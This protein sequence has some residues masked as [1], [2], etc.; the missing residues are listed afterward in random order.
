MKN[1]NTTTSIPVHKIFL[2]KK[3]QHSIPGTDYTSINIEDTFSVALNR[4]PTSY[5]KSTSFVPASSKT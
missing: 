4:H 1:A 5:M 3:D 2:T